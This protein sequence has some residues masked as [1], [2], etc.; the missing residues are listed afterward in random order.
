MGNLLVKQSLLIL[1]L[2]IFVNYKVSETFANES[3]PDII[4]E[5]YILIDSN[6]GK[7]LLQE[8]AHQLMYPASI[9]KIITAIIVIETRDLDEVVEVSWDAVRAIGTRVY[10]LEGEKITLRQLLHGLMVSSGNDAAIA[11]AEHIDGSVEAFAERMNDFVETRIGVQ[12]SNFKNPHGLFEEEHMTT[13]SDMAKISAYA[14][15]NDF[16]RELVSTEYYDWVGEGWET[17]IY[18][19]HPLTRHYEDI[20]GIK[21][22]FVQRSGTTLSTAAK[23][24]ETELITVTLKAPSRYFAQEDTLA[25]LEYGFQNYET[26][27][28]TFEKEPLRYDFVYPEKIPVTT[29]IGESVNYTISSNGIVTISSDAGKILKEFQLQERKPVLSP[30]LLD[31]SILDQGQNDSDNKKFS[32]LD[33]L[34][35]TGIPLVYR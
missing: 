5:S 17:R 16:F 28:V 33:W 32:W 19:H 7:V 2:L 11:I 8:N 25:L 27:W 1:F 12:R 10:L 18:N 9:T 30:V 35:V 13:A 3:A 29:E 34:F 6:T 26:Q 23:R 15:K 22:G 24:G 31:K 21:N 4:S 20:I 14:M